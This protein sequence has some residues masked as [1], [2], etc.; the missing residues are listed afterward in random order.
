MSIQMRQIDPIQHSGQQFALFHTNLKFSPD[1]SLVEARP[2]SFQ[3]QAPRLGGIHV[4]KSSGTLLLPSV[5]F[6]PV[7]EQGETRQSPS[8]SRPLC[9][10]NRPYERAIK[11]ICDFAAWFETSVSMQGA[12]AR[13]A[14]LSKQD[15]PCVPY[16]PALAARGL[17]LEHTLFVESHN[18]AQSLAELCEDAFFEALVIESP[19]TPL[20]LKIANRFLK[21]H[22]R[23]RAST[24][25]AQPP[26]HAME[27]S[28]DLW[29]GTLFHQPS[30]RAAQ[31]ASLLS[32][33]RPSGTGNATRTPSLP[34]CSAV[35]I[36][37][38]EHTRLFLFLD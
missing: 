21:S 22:V 28:A 33:S 25:P 16:P 8:S 4:F 10:A 14:W 30:T 24:A 11:H 1:G 9:L 5:A 26:S 2:S 37:Q 3:A 13:I 19:P 23:S 36:E 31:A 32:L 15:A 17:P 34:L 27:P 18:I 38:R 20:L 7:T 6:R 29:K 35:E 12:S